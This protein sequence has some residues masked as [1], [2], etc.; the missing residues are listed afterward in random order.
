MK[1]KIV[2]NKVAVANDGDTEIYNWLCDIAK[3]HHRIQIFL[4]TTGFRSRKTLSCMYKHFIFM[5]ITNTIMNDLCVLY[6]TLDVIF[7]C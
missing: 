6:V 1:I 5:F 2:Q 4:E 7:K 3:S